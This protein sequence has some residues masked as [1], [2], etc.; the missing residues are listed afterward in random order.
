[1]DFMSWFPFYLMV[2]RG[3]ASM[4][5]AARGGFNTQ[6]EKRAI[7]IGAWAVAAAEAAAAM[8]CNEQARY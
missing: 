6:L 1:M 2:G 4:V 3:T 5:R 8:A 7:R